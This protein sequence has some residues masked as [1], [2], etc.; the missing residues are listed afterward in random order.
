MKLRGLTAK[1]PNSGKG[2]KT[3]KSALGLKRPI[4]VHASQE[5]PPPAISTTSVILVGVRSKW[6]RGSILLVAGNS[7]AT[8]PVEPRAIFGP[9]LNYSINLKSLNLEPFSGVP[10]APETGLPFSGLPRLAGFIAWAVSGSNA[11]EHRT[12][13]TRQYV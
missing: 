3:K 8:G 2:E 9:E 10:R 1:C 6:F 13:F 7:W 11:A 4:F 5:A 12:G